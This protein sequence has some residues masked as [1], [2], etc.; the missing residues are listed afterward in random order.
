M[1]LS[2]GRLRPG[3]REDYADFA[4]LFGELGVEEPPPP[5]TLW[6]ADMVHR[7]FFVEGPAGPCAYALTDVLGETGYV[8]NLVVAPGERRR[9]LG[10]EMM[11]A[12][13]AY[14]RG[15]GCRE[16]MLNVK[17]DNVAAVALYTA[18][19]MERGLEDMSL[20][21]TREQV[22]ALPAAPVGVEV[23]PVKEAELAPLT[24]AA[25]LVPGKLARYATLPGHQLWRLAHP[26]ESRVGLWGM[27]DV[28]SAAGVLFPFFAV[29]PGAARAL[30][31]AGLRELR[32]ESLRVV[33]TGAELQ[34]ALRAVGATVGLVT[35]RM[36][37]PLP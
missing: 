4:R 5:V 18:M 17:P 1:V 21:L 34:S 2:T 19:G 27:M 32:A 11:Y 37:G 13:A 16:W 12:L 8:V 14:F 25:G 31:E 10:R 29:S 22:R 7:S 26:E 30:L 3:R 9:G 20:R 28:R 6:E 35:L 15:R 33:V 23:V 36:Q 24:A